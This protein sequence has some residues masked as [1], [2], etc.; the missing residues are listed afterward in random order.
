MIRY[1]TS[2]ICSGT[3]YLLEIKSF[4]F[5]SLISRNW[6]VCNA[7]IGKLKKNAKSQVPSSK[8]WQSLH[9]YLVRDVGDQAVGACLPHQAQ[10]DLVTALKWK[11]ERVNRKE[12][13]NRKESVNRKECVNRK[14]SVDR[15]E[16]VNVSPL[17]IILS[18]VKQAFR[19]LSAYY[20]LKTNCL[21]KT[22]V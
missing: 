8:P 18:R 3:L 17:W 19:I 14:E 22:A 9:T 2:C 20:N 7:M 12:C 15:K 21:K 13:V 16:S 5:W 10:Q 11:Q 4:L 1:K 6:T